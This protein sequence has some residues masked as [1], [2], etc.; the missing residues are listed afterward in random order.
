METQALTGIVAPTGAG[1]WWLAPIILGITA[2]AWFPHWFYSRPTLRIEIVQGDITTEKV[3][4]IVNA[5]KSS[6]L[7]GGGVDGAIHRAGGPAILAECKELRRDLPDGLPAGHALIT[8]A[9]ALPAQWVVHTV[10]PVYDPRKDLSDVLRSCYTQSLEAADVTG[11][12]TVAFPLISAGVYG[13]PKDDAVKQA[14]TAI[15]SANTQ[16]KTV[17]L[18]VFDEDTYRIALAQAEV[19]R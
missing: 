14:L 5:A 10:G 15:R 11:A 18:V 2:L 4:V 6:L 13:W 16:V 12:R 7:G 1:W 19:T 8:T 3:D 9:G 17:R